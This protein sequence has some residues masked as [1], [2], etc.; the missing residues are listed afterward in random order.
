MAYETSKCHNLRVARS[1]FDRYLKGD[2]LDI[3]CGPDPIKPPAGT[4]RPWDWEDGDASYLESLSD[5]SF[6][7]VYSSHCLEH[8]H[9]VVVA[10]TNW[11]RVVKVGGHLYFTIPDFDI[12]EKGV[13]PSMFNP[14]HK[15]T[16]SMNKTRGQVGRSNHFNIL[17]D[18]APLM[19]D[20]GCEFVRAD[21]EDHGYDYTRPQ[22]DQT[23]G[24]ALAQI[25]TVWK[26]VK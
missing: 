1:D 11:V 20:L 26:K 7:C 23:L 15:Q 2:I 19:Q 12:Y 21:F 16:F 25:C 8:L 14:D 5:E 18:L 24:M 10:L 13:W 6:D 4:T 3:G 22:D 17:H 9:D